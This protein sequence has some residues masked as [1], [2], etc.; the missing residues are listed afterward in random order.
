MRRAMLSF[1]QELKPYTVYVGGTNGR[2]YGSNDL[3]SWEEF[4]AYGLGTV[5]ALVWMPERKRLW[6]GG[7][8]GSYGFSDDFGKTWT[9]NTSGSADFYA[10][11]YSSSTDSLVAVQNTAPGGVRYST[12][13]GAVLNSATAGMVPLRGVGI[14]NGYFIVASNSSAFFTSDNGSLTSW[15]GASMT[16]SANFGDMVAV[17]RNFNGATCVISNVLQYDTSGQPTNW[18]T[19]SLAFPRQQDMAEN[20]TMTI[21]VGADGRIVYG[22]SSNHHMNHSTTT[23][24]SAA[25]GITYSPKLGLFILAGTRTIVSTNYGAVSTTSNGMS[26]SHAWQTNSSSGFFSVCHTE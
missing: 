20:G 3:F 22:G 11:A 2:I 12:A 19:A 6:A 8:G 17:G 24:M 25:N 10:A 13:G 7:E 18:S 9:T 26:V 5:R 14:N 21:S 4:T 23:N 15:N 1:G 16:H